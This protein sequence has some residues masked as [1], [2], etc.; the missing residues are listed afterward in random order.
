MWEK[1]LPRE[2]N[3]MSEALMEIIYHYINDYTDMWDIEESID[4]WSY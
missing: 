4:Y 3:I 2:R 1:H